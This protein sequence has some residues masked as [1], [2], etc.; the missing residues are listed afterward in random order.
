MGSSIR[1]HAPAARIMHNAEILI[2]RYVCASCIMQAPALQ[3]SLIP[4]SVA[5]RTTTASMTTQINTLQE[6]AAFPVVLS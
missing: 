1:R 5:N 6:M 2:V 4:S 3:V